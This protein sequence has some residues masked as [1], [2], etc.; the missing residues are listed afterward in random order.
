MPFIW[1]SNP[2]PPT[3][4]LPQP[5]PPGEVTYLVDVVANTVNAGGSLLYNTANTSYDVVYALPSLNVGNLT[6]THSA[7]INGASTITILNAHP[8]L[9]TNGII[10]HANSGVVASGYGGASVIPVFVVD[11]TGHVTSVTNTAIILSGD[12][13]ASN[14]DGTL[15][16]GNSA[17]G[18]FNVNPLTPGTGILVNNDRG[19]I[20]LVATGDPILSGHRYGNA[21]V[22]RRVMNSPS[23]VQYDYNDAAWNGS[24]HVLVPINIS[25]NVNKVSTSPDGISWSTH[26]VPDGEWIIVD[27]NGSYFVCMGLH[28]GGVKVMTSP[29][30]FTWTRHEGFL[31]TINLGAL[32]SA[33]HQMTWNGSVFAV[34][35]KT[36]P[37]PALF[38]AD[39]ITWT[40]TPF[41]SHLNN[42]GIT[43]GSGLFVAVGYNTAIST[44]S[45]G[46]NWVSRSSSSNDATHMLNSVAWNGS[47]FVAVGDGVEVLTSPDGITWTPHD[48]VFGNPWKSVVWSPPLGLWCTVSDSGVGAQCLTSPNGITWTA[49]TLSVGSWETINWNGN[50]FVASGFYNG[51]STP[52]IATSPDGINWTVRT[53]AAEPWRNITWNGSFF[54]AVGPNNLM[55]SPDGIAWLN[56]GIPT[57]TWVASA[58]NGSVFAVIG[59]T[60]AVVTSPNALAWTVQTSM[61]GSRSSIAW[62]AGLFVVVGT[63]GVKTSPDG[64]T[65]TTRTSVTGTWRDVVWNGNLFVAVS[66]SGDLQTSPDGITWSAKSGVFGEWN[67]IAWSGS[68]FA[69]V[70]NS[71]GVVQTSSDGTTWTARAGISGRWID[72]AWDGSVFAAVGPNIVMTSPDGF[73][74]TNRNNIPIGNWQSIA[75]NDNILV[76]VSN[77]TTSIVMSNW[78]ESV[79]SVSGR[80]GAILLNTND[81]SENIG[82]PFYHTSARVRGN[83][84]GTFPLSYDQPNGIFSHTNSGVAASGY[85]DAATVAKVVVDAFG[86][87]T[88]VTNTAIAGLNAGVITTGT[89]VVARGGTGQSSYTNGQI[90][91]GNTGSTGLDKALIAQSAPV[92]VTVAQGL[93]TLSHARSGVVAAVYGNASIIP[94]VTVDANGHIT[95]AVNTA[96]A[97]LSTGV[98]TTGILSVARGGTGKDATGLANGQLLIGNTVNTGFD[99]ATI[100]QSSPVIVTVGQGAITLS[101]AR[102]GVVAGVYGNA[103]LIPVITVDANGHLTTVANTAV[104][105]LPSAT[106]NGQ[107]LIGNTVS[108]GFDLNLL[109]QGTGIVITNDKG[110]ITIASPTTMPTGN[111]LSGDRVFYEN[112]LNVTANYTLTTGRSAMS[113][114]PITVN[115]NVIVTIPSGSRWTVV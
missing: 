9:F 36:T 2:N 24:I 87:V 39:G 76:S 53:N 93:I 4:E 7:N 40:A 114:G 43:A 73:H 105:T 28:G 1:N 32:G 34:V 18:H 108:G 112:D 38:S 110:S 5:V 14:G 63:S 23:E 21:W 56:R 30:G 42:G 26:T 91:I 71:G 107:L 97:G 60:G 74:W 104:S 27:S 75:W 31:P 19:S 102:S 16:I 88:S 86:H 85:G 79:T 50:L 49:R 3:R 44:S 10:S 96:I 57:G 84:S 106:A 45:N 89:L 70:S 81:V 94:S 100:A 37:F 99:L 22:S 20:T 11:T 51:G 55:T 33:S 113:A 80:V 65:W 103:T 66:G 101:H 59:S 111:S 83:V 82:G 90:L 61:G 109:T 98:L 15:L 68:V 13:L 67:A 17:T 12:V 8:I 46:N 41:P 25:V 58:W 95:A 69:A 29:D 62:G 77:S 78:P 48:H 64:V 92:I 47:Y 54:I 115:P 52:T 35:P 72:V 6:V